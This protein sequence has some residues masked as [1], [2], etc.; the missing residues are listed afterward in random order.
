LDTVRWLGFEP[1]KITHSSDY[2]QELYELALKL[3]Q[4]GLVWNRS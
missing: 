3:I 1:Y 4:K 2:F